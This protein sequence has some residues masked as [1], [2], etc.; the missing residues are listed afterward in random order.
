MRLSTCFHSRRAAAAGDAGVVD[1]RSRGAGR[2]RVA[3]RDV[4]F[5]S[6]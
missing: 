2:Q 3:E 6:G 5:T 1:E 4:T